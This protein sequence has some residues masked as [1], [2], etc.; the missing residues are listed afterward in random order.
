MEI[1]MPI[2]TLDSFNAGYANAQ[3]A[4]QQACFHQDNSYRK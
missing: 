2:D 1:A 3:V 4:S